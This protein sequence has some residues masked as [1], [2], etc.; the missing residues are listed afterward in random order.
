MKKSRRYLTMFLFT[1]LAVLLLQNGYMRAEEIENRLPTENLYKPDEIRDG[2]DRQQVTPFGDPKFYFEIPIPKGWESRPYEI[3]KQDL[4]DAEMGAAMVRMAMFTPN[5]QDE[6]NVMIE[7]HF[8]R[9]PSRV[10]LSNWMDTALA[11]IDSSVLDRQAG[12]YNGRAVE[13]VLLARDGDIALLTRFT[14]SRHGDYIFIVSG[15]APKEQ[16]QKYIR[17]FGLAA[18]AFNPLGTEHKP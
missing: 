3:S 15:T 17:I 18:V 13:D 4:T 6:K 9:V 10:Q 11:N 16:Y 2:F 7:V 14:A 12:E 8:M 5:S 1:L